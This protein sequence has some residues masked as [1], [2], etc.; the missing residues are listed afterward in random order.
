MSVVDWLR[1]EC[2]AD[3]LLEALLWQG[4]PSCAH[5][6][7]MKITKLKGG[8]SGLWKC[9]SCRK[10][11]SVRSI[12]PFRNIHIKSDAFLQGIYLKSAFGSLS[13]SRLAEII[14]ISQR[15]AWQLKRRYC[16]ARVALEMVDISEIELM[17]QLADEQPTDCSSREVAPLSARNRYERFRTAI[18]DVDAS[19][20]DLIFIQTLIA[21]KYIAADKKADLLRQLEFNFPRLIELGPEQ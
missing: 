3:C 18:A 10:K 5:C 15:S 7:S 1:D 14:G 19:R 11:F 17:K 16:D 4:T 12:G 21:L 13:C 2:L 9:Y 20:A 6:S 8:A